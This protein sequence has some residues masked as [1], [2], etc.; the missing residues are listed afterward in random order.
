MIGTFVSSLTIY[1]KVTSKEWLAIKEE[2]I[3]LTTMNININMGEQSSKN[4]NSFENHESNERNSLQIYQQHSS[5]MSETK[6]KQ[7]SLSY[8]ARILLP[9]SPYNTKKTLFLI[10]FFSIISLILATIGSVFISF[11][12]V[13]ISIP[14]YVIGGVIWFFTFISL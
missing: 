6:R 13:Q 8:D 9:K 7:S 10:I 4:M 3:N 11:A 2:Q 5:M 1:K 12:I 14:F